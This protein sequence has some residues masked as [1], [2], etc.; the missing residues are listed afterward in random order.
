[1]KK[2]YWIMMGCSL[3]LIIINIYIFG[4]YRIDYRD[5][6]IPG[7]K[8]RI[9]INK[10]NKNMKMTIIDY[11]S[12]IDCESEKTQYKIILTKKEYDKIK[13]IIMLKNETGK[14]CTGLRMLVSDE[15]KEGNEYLDN[16]LKTKK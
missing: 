11:C 10:V 16:I 2:K 8:Y 1:M 15:R 9:I 12:A 4:F 3:I 7:S 13:K 14:L 6:Y 5:D